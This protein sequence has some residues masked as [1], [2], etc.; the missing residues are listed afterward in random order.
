MRRRT[1]RRTVVVGT[2]RERPVRGAAGRGRARRALVSQEGVGG[3]CDHRHRRRTT[4]PA[5]TPT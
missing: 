3:V 1:A 5:A 4:S 2:A